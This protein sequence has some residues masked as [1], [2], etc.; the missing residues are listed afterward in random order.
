MHP[1]RLPNARGTRRVPLRGVAK[2]PSR[3]RFVALFDVLSKIRD[4]ALA[5]EQTYAAELALV[6]EEYRPSARNLLHYLVL[7]QHDLRVMQIELAT[8]GLSSLGRCEANVLATLD[9]LLVALSALAGLRPPAFARDV[10]PVDQRSGPATL[11]RHARALL[12]RTSARRAVTIMVTLGSEAATDYHLVRDL[13]AAGM[14]QARINS[15]HDSLGEWR[16]MIALVR[17]AARE[18][19]RECRVLFDL[20]G[21]KL[22]TGTLVPGP[23]IVHWRPQRDDCGRVVAPAHVTLVATGRK[24]QSATA[25]TVLPVDG[26]FLCRAR[27]DDRIHLIDERGKSRSLRIAAGNNGMRLA[28]GGKT[29][30][31]SPGTTLRLLRRRKLIAV[32]RLGVLPSRDK[33]LLLHRGDTLLVTAG[34]KPGHPS[35]IAANGAIIEPACIP[36]T[37][38]EVLT[39]VRVGERIWFDDGKIGGVIRRTGIDAGDSAIAVEITHVADAGAKLRPDKGINLPDSALTLP[40]LSPKDRTDLAFAVAH[41]DLVGLSFVRSPEDVEAVEQAM[42]D[43]GAR[44]LGLVLKIETPQGFANLPRI[45]LAGLRAPSLG[46]LLARGDLAVEVGFERLAEV[47]EEILWLCEAAHVPVIWGTQV[48]E[49]LAKK[50]IP[51]RAEVTDAAMSGRAECVMLNKGPHVLDAVRFLDNV[52]ARMQAHQ[53]KKRSLLRRLLVSEMA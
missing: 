12:G 1:H 37:L 2:T 28:E 8:Y 45:L 40:I 16:K 49:G 27:I 42:T 31:V 53:T 7:R 13:V 52:L 50:G 10:V 38:P 6:P 26:R 24:H 39:Q 46:V 17:R 9:A 3:V 43:L 44:H 41:A 19:K 14:N 21:P 32:T 48:L 11:V 36:C 30:Y 15:A 34:A 22:R 51:S 20:A 29:A 18:L 5:N 35:R 33:P 25:D 47:Q 4:Q 23:Q